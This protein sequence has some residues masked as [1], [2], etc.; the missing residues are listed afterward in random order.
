MMLN[1][2]DLAIWI[3]AG[4]GLGIGTIGTLA[5]LWMSK[6]FDRRYAQTSK[7]GGTTY[8]AYH[9]HGVVALP[10]GA[11]IHYDHGASG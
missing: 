2:S 10:R 8:G 11:Q 4:L 7:D 5:G 1:N 6:S 9:T 3:V